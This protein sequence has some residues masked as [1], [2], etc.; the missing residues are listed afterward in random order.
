MRKNNLTREQAEEIYNALRDRV[1]AI[2]KKNENKARPSVGDETTNVNSLEELRSLSEN[3]SRGFRFTTFLAGMTGF[4]LMFISLGILLYNESPT[5]KDIVKRSSL[6]FEDLKR[7]ALSMDNLEEVA[8][9]LEAKRINLEQKEE[10][11]N[12]RLQEQKFI[13]SVIQEKLE[14]LKAHI[15]KIKNLQNEQSAQEKAK[16]DMLVNLLLSMPAKDAANLLQGLDNDVIVE[17]LAKM[18][19]R[20]SGN[21]LNFFNRD[22]AVRI[23][24]LMSQPE[25]R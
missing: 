3:Q 4:G 18:P 5:V 1:N 13:E 20:R 17:I 22:R 9:Q 8:L 19:E 25:L 21:I 16:I 24:K 10:E 15:N 12:V 14:E 23:A 2:I 11:L 6:A 7:P